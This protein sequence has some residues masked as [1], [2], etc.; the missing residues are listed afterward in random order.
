MG[1]TAQSSFTANSASFIPLSQ[2]TLVY[3]GTVSYPSPGNW[4]EVTLAT[5][6]EYDGTQ[7]LVIGLDENTPGASTGL[8]WGVFS[9]PSSSRSIG[10]ESTTDIDPAAPIRSFN[11][12]SLARLQLDLAPLT[13]VTLHMH[14]PDSSS[15]EISWSL[16]KNQH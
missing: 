1:Q 11:D 15:D 12:N 5:P 8:S 3:S 7:N 6:F 2:L 10:G 16:E 9:V 14:T 13:D 4:L